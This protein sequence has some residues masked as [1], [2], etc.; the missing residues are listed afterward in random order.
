MREWFVDRDAPDIGEACARHNVPL[1]ETPFLNCDE[2]RTAMR[3][4]N[5]DLGLSLGN[6][7]IAESVFSIPRHGMLNIH[8]EILPQFQGA[9][10]IIWPIHQGVRET[11]FTIHRINRTIDAGDIVFQAKYPIEFRPTLRAT[12][13]HNLSR[14]RALI[15]SAFVEVCERFEALSAGAK[16]QPRVQSFTTPSYW[17]YRRMERNNA[18]FYRG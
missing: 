4:A 9:Q 10:S 17:A 12:V 5:A 13:E 11:G 6:G 8:T 1:V 3:E 2:T 15:P 14:A 7:Y 18:R 16:A